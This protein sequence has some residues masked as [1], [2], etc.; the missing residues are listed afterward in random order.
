MLTATTENIERI[1]REVMAQLGAV[2]TAAVAPA[3]AAAPPAVREGNV[4]LDARVVTLETIA[5]RLQGAKQLL[6]A[7][8]PWSPRRS[9]MSCGARALRWSGEARRPFARRPAACC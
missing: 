7:P 9:T 8:Q 1:V 2:P 4:C 3:P 6:V 5:G